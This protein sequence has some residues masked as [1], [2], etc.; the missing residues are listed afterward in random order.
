MWG[1]VEVELCPLKS[2]RFLCFLFCSGIRSMQQIFHPNFSTFY[3]RIEFPFP[4]SITKGHKRRSWGFEIVRR[5]G[6]NSSVSSSR[7]TSSSCS[8][9]GL[10]ELQDIFIVGG[11]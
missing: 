4:K 7:A 9:I 5:L 1:R 2:S 8:C 3:L 11:V 10:S 6:M